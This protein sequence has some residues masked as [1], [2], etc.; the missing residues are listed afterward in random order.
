VATCVHALVSKTATPRNIPHAARVLEMGMMRRSVSRR[1]LS[2][3]PST[4]R[5]LR[6][7]RLL[8][9]CL[10]LGVLAS[11]APAAPP[12]CVDAVAWTASAPAATEEAALESADAE[13]PRCSQPAPPALDHDA[14]S[15]YPPGARLVVV[16]HRVYL[17]HAALLC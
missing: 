1:G 12:S 6:S 8:V 15:S 14:A 2:R 5:L 7:L 10:A 16:H 9:A 3:G 13:L 17:R 4:A 11:S